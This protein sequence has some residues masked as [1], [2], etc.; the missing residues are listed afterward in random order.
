VYKQTESEENKEMTNTE[1]TS[2]GWETM[3][4]AII[5]A[6]F[7]I[8]GTWP[9]RTELTTAL[10]TTVNA[11]ASSIAIVYRPRAEDAP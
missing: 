11:L 5:N 7:S 3:I 1:T 4:Q 6:G 10:K 8:T 9:L 2:S